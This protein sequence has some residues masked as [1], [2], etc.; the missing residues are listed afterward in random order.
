MGT[1]DET[2]VTP[3]GRK[4]IRG[5]LW[6]FL[7]R[8]IQQTLS[9]VRTIILAR[10]LS[11]ND[12]GLFGIALL[13]LSMLDTFSQPGFKTALI[14]KKENITDYLNTTWT[15]E[16]IRSIFIAT[17]LFLLPLKPRYFS[18]CHKLNCF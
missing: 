17:I 6:V 10:L 15:V 8:I 16:I 9:F 4:V 7:T 13:L 5:G 2:V 18:G 11:P 12:F 1:F 14:Q 3:F